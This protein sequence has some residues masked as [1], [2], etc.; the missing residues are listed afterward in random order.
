ME[1]GV[2]M[3]MARKNIICDPHYVQEGNTWKFL[4]V[5]LENNKNSALWVFP[6]QKLR[7]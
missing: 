2:L 1:R 5:S 4:A 6:S 7:M 3:D